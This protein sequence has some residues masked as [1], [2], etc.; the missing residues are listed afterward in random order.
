MTTGSL[1]GLEDV[2]H[3]I[4]G[5]LFGVKP[6][7]DPA[8]RDG[9]QTDDPTEEDYEGEPWIPQEQF[10]AGPVNLILADPVINIPKACPMWDGRTTQVVTGKAQRIV[11][12]NPH[13][14]RVRIVCVG[15][16]DLNA[17]AS[18]AIGGHEGTVYSANGNV[19]GFIIQP[20]NN[21][22]FFGSP[23]CEAIIETTASV[24]A[25]LNPAASLPSCSVAILEEF[26]YGG[27][28]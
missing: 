27:V 17:T 8:W 23:A 2:V 18:I 24:W 25:T 28:D 9:N 16:S 6:V 26:D 3:N 10:L 20:S 4:L 13:R 1:T 7:V 21:T 14:R 22:I 11:Q 12:A 5:A 15:A 19:G